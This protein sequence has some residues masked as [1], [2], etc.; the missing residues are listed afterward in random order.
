MQDH[1]EVVKNYK[2]EQSKQIIKNKI[3]T[4]E[5]VLSI[6]NSGIAR[7]K[8]SGDSVLRTTLLIDKLCTIVDFGLGY[9]NTQSN[10]LPFELK[11]EI[12]RTSQIVTQELNFILD[13]VSNPIYS[14][15]NTKD[16]NKDTNEDLLKKNTKEYNNVSKIYKDEAE[17]IKVKDQIKSIEI[18]LSL[19]NN[20]IARHKRSGDPVLRTTLLVDKLCMIVDLGLAYINTQDDDLPLEL[21]ERI[22]ATSEM[23]TQE[24]NFMLDWISHP[25]YS[26]D[27]PYG[28]NI[29]KEANKEFDLKK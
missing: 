13:W 7:H 19:V 1:I 28:N 12:T 9:I 16:T 29:M 24:L 6:L 2:D 20:G 8:R 23:V 18:M 4:F 25:V 14:E 15:N 5:I 11:E 27:H 26:P 21:I 3:N 10:D 17:E 22:T